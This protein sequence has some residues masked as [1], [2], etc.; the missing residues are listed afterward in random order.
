VAVDSSEPCRNG[1]AEAIPWI[2][3]YLGLRRHNRTIVGDDEDA[4]DLEGSRD[5]ISQHRNRRR[6]ADRRGQPPLRVAAVRDHDRRHA[7][8]RTQVPWRRSGDAR[9]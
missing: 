5:D 9:K 7:P 8:K 4:P 6:G 2:V 3:D 1:S